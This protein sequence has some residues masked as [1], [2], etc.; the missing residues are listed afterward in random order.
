MP[1]IYLTGEAISKY[2]EESGN[3][4][5]NYDLC[6]SCYEEVMADPESYLDDFE[7]Y[8]GEPKP[9]GFEG[10]GEHPPYDECDY[11]CEL[12]KTPLTEEDD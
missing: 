4:S 5:S 7:P 6:A 9:T 8:N 11:D 12:C 10:E 2:C 3:G 1:R